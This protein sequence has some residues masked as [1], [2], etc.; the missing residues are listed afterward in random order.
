[1]WIL[2]GSSFY[3]HDL[4]VCLDTHIHIFRCMYI[5]HMRGKTL[6]VFLDLVYVTEYDVFQLHP[7]SCNCYFFVAK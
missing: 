2:D 6:F 4:H 3:F 5:L 7:F 1:M